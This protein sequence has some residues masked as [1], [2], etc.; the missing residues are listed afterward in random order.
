MNLKHSCEARRSISPNLDIP[1]LHR[2][3]GGLRDP[4]QLGELLLTQ[5]VELASEPERLGRS[6]LSVCARLEYRL[7]HV[8]VR[9]SIARTWTVW[10]MPLSFRLNKPQ[11]VVPWLEPLTAYPQMSKTFMKKLL[12]C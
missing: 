12:S 8:R 11:K 6:Q 1:T 10:F 5:L 7:N 9:I 2:G 3:D 4:G